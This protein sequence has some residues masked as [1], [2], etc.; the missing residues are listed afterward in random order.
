MRT[1]LPRYAVYRNGAKDE[2]IEEITD[3]WTQDSVAFLPGSSLSFDDA[4]ARAGV[5][6]GETVWALNTAP[7]HGFI[8][9][10]RSDHFCIP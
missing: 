6:A 9:D 10:L 8:T 3:M 7:A 2:E 4:L 5:E 1:D